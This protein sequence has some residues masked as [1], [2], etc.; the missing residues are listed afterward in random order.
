M[1]GASAF[2]QAPAISPQGVQDAASYGTS[3]V[4]GGIFV[5]KGANLSNAGT[6]QSSLPLPTIL[7]G[8][9][10]TFTAASGGTGVDAF[11]IYTFFASGVNQIAGLLPS[12]V[13]PG[14]YNVTVT[15]NGQVSVPA[16]VTVVNRKFGLITVNSS[17][18][19]RAVVQNFVSPS[20]LDLNRF[21]TGQIAGFI[22]SPAKPGQVLIAWG[23]GLGAI[24]RPDNEAPGAV[25]LRSQVDVKVLVGNSTVTPSYAGRAPSLPGADQINFQLPADVQTGCNVPIQ[26][27]V[28]GVL[29]NPA[30]LAI[31]PAGAVSCVQP[32]IGPDVL[33]RLDSGQTVAS[34]IFALSSFAV[35]VTFPL[36]GSI[37][38]KTEQITGT[39]A[40]F[41]ADQLADTTGFL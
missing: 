19:G 5:V 16:A 27:S 23:T 35:N 22:I 28:G 1:I 32:F 9:K 41:S 38:A 39:F 7:D 2:A 8:V 30:T 10:I 26:I 4:P 15:F 36:L 11:M 29:S 21:T 14:N 31:A 40:R 6:R 37:D 18:A 34:G 24:Q 13:A 33:T 17:G 20:Q 3:L 25:D 12:S